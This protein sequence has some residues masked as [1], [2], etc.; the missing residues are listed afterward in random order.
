MT[1]RWR[2]AAPPPVAEIDGWADCLPTKLRE[3]WPLLAYA[4]A[5][6]EGA[7]FGGT[8]L[9]IHLRHRQSFDL[10]YLVAGPFDPSAVASRLA[11]SAECRALGQDS[12]AL[13]VVANGVTVEVFRPPTRGFN[14]GVERR[15]QTPRIVDGLAVA[16]LAD[17]LASKL[18]LLLYRQK[19]R[20]Y[21]DVAAIDARGAYSIEDGLLFHEERY[22]ETPGSFEL[23]R[24]VD[25]LEDPGTLPS[26]GPFEDRRG[27]ALSYLRA[28]APALRRW[29][30]HQVLADAVEAG[31]AP[32]DRPDT[33]GPIDRQIRT[34]PP[35]TVDI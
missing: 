27:E 24:I 21:I 17:L 32:E 10:D 4:V 25:L 30:H 34:D 15:L 14:P 29:L 9:A 35:S 16:S 19:L 22:G 13:R 31:A 3:V 20:D 2:S 18:D 26:D 1:R 12:D 8:A 7:L 11:A 33:A 5:G 23:A 28:R 6:V